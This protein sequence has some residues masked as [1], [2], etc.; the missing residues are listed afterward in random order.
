LALAVQR[1]ERKSSERIESVE[2][3]VSKHRRQ[4]RTR[5]AAHNGRGLDTSF[6]VRLR[7]CSLWA[8]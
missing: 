1:D 7:Q 4:Q 8:R 3:I 2:R 6:P 5:Y